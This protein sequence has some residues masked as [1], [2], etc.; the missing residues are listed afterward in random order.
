MNKTT[1][2]RPRQSLYLPRMERDATIRTSTMQSV[3]KTMSARKTTSKFLEN[4]SA[5]GLPNI[6]RVA[7]PARKVFWSVAFLSSLIGFCY[8]S[9]ELIK[10]YLEHPYV[11]EFHVEYSRDVVFPMVSFCNLN[12]V[13]RGKLEN[14]K[15]DNDYIRRFIAVDWP[16]PLFKTK[17]QHKNHAHVGPS[18]PNAELENQVPRTAV[19]GSTEPTVTHGYQGTEDASLNNQMGED[20]NTLGLLDIP[21][22]Q[23]MT[24]DHSLEQPME[25][26]TPSLIPTRREARPRHRQRN[27]RAEDLLAS[28]VPADFTDLWTNRTRQPKFFRRPPARVS[29]NIFST[30]AYHK[31]LSPK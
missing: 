19:R 10:Y 12:P 30:L 21:H 17:I 26:D 24:L 2:L 23:N 8:Q 28:D 16:V 4:T 9:G 22:D 18:P 14:S 29:R 27:K 5:H 6:K 20:S 1:K 3:T 25:T 15:D 11:V 13:S 31:Y 7:S